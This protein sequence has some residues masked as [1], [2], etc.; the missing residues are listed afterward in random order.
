MGSS[1]SWVCWHRNRHLII[2]IL[3][4]LVSSFSTHLSFIAEATRPIPTKLPEAATSENAGGGERINARQIGS[5]PPQCMRACT[6]CGHCV[7]VQVPVAPQRH[8]NGE[9][10]SSSRGAATTSTRKTSPKR[11]AYSRGGDELSNY[12]PISWKCKCGDLFFNP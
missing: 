11:P 2:P 5:R 6:G 3:L 7:A 4:V 9:K 1:Q 8:N 12:K 10:R